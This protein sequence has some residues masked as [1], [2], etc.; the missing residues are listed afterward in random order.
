MQ[1][2]YKMVVRVP[3]EWHRRVKAEAALRG[4]S[5]SQLIRDAVNEYL[6]KDKNLRRNKVWVNVD[7]VKE[8]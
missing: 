2:D 5:L 8:P 3:K 1:N 4:I 7:T 6:E